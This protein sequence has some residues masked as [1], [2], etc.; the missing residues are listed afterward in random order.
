MAGRGHWRDFWWPD[1]AATGVIGIANHS[2]DHAHAALPIICQRDQR[3]GT[4]L[5]IDNESDADAQI[6]QAQRFI[7]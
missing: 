1:L 3:K 4:F 7:W 5:G 6:A 2:W